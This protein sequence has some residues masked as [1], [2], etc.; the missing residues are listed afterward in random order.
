MSSTMRAYVSGENTP[1][2]L[3]HRPVPTP[4]HDEVLIRTRAAALNNSDLTPSGDDH[5]AGFEFAG[6]VIE[7]GADAP[8]QLRGTRVM[9]IA[10]G[11]L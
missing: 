5:I 7:V 1:L 9:G 6:D 11:A 4:G 3:A 10:A 2:T 8:T